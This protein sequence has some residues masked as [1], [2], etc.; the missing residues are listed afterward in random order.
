VA[1]V[2]AV[3]AGASDLFEVASG[4]ELLDLRGAL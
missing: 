1:T 4:Q 2:V 3:G